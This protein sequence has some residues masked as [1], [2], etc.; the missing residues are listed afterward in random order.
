MTKNNLEERAY[1][2]LQFQMDSVHSGEEGLAAG[3][4]SREITFHLYRGSRQGEQEVT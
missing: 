2:G 4:G 1:L 3:A